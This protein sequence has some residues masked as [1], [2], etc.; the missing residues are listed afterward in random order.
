MS[1]ISQ[2]F[3]ALLDTLIKSKDYYT[4][5]VFEF[6][7]YGVL[8]L[9]LD[10]SGPKIWYLNS[11]FLELVGDSKSIKSGSTTR[12]FKTLNKKT[13][14]GAGMMEAN[15]CVAFDAIL[16]VKDKGIIEVRI[17]G[18]TFM[19]E[20]QSAPH[21]LGAVFQSHDLEVNEEK[22]LEIIKK[23]SETPQFGSVG[24]VNAAHVIKD[25]IETLRQT[26]LKWSNRFKTISEPD[27]DT[28]ED[29]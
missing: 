27:F 11:S 16:K 18:K 2:E 10:K 4:S 21:F 5:Q 14:E 29:A 23:F 1:S 3:H 24:V 7:P 9:Y 12:F 6:F 17:T 26:T 28:E 19:I 8:G 22:T 13:L 15:K 20:G 25:N